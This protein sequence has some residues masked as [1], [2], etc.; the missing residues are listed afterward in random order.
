MKNV[1]KFGINSNMLK[2]IAVIAMVIDHIGFYFSPYLN[3]GVYLVCR[4]I[5][6]MAMPI[7]T[8]LIVQGF[9][10]TKNFNKY[11]T[12][13]F[14]F[15][16]ITQILIWL[17]MYLNIKYVPGYV[18]A[19]QVYLTGNI[20]LTFTIS[21]ALLKLLHEKILINKWE[22]NKNLSLRIILVTALTVIAIFLPLDYMVEVLMLS[23]FMYYI[24][25]L[26]LMV[27]IN[28]S[29]ATNINGMGSVNFNINSVFFKM[30][31]DKKIKLIYTGLLLLSLILISI[32]FRNNFWMLLAIIPI[33][34]YNDERGKNTKNSKFAYYIF[35][36]LH[37]V[38]LYSLAL[39][40]TL[41]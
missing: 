20:L 26:K 24:E 13:I 29:Q 14:G 8:Y 23:V 9:F 36:P 12:R 32:Y 39:A 4:I 3:H 25:R 6:R 27:Y 37:H 5:G 15:G 28:K 22:Y 35:F 31:D 1:I 19:K 7:F 17:M 11:I 30:I 18:A 10:H 38:L 16:V 33:S 21:L 34:L 2:T 40:L 41:T